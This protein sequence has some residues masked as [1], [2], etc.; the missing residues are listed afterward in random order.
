V[1]LLQASTARARSNN[2]PVIMDLRSR[3]KLHLI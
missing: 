3:D 2:T 1:L